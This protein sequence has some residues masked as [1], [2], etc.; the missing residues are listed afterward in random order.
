MCFVKWLNWITVYRESIRY[1]QDNFDF[2]WIAYSG[3]PN[4]YIASSDESIS[5]KNTADLPP[6]AVM[7]SAWTANSSSPFPF[8]FTPL[9]GTKS[10]MLLYFAEIEN[11]RM[12]ESI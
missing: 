1:P 7:Q 9:E 8:Q 12:S 2:L 3:L 11:L 6:T 4:S 5:T 10:L